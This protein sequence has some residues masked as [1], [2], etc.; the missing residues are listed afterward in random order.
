MQLLGGGTPK[1][2]MSYLDENAAF[3]GGS[4]A[5]GATP[6]VPANAS[7]GGATINPAAAAFLASMLK[8]SNAQAPGV[9]APPLPGIPSPLMRQGPVTPGD[10]LRQAMMVASL[11][12][13]AGGRRGA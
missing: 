8:G 1:S 3:L 13:L 7:A 10:F 2:D 12:D 9:T 6:N 5:S 4:T 11:R